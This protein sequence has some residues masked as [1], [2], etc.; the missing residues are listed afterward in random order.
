MMAISKIV[1]FGLETRAVELKNQHKSNYEIARILSKEAGMLIARDSVYEYFKTHYE[2]L[3]QLAKKDVKFHEEMLRQHL[4][5]DALLLFISQKAKAAVEKLEADPKSNPGRMAALL[6]VLLREVEFL[7]KRLGMVSDA[8]Q[9]NITVINQEFN[10]FKTIMFDVIQEVGGDEL[11]Q[12]VL[13]A[14]KSRIR[15]ESR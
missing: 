13:E 8:P 14:L 6:T 4:E 1:M 5:V 9:T 7:A 2:I 15:Q 12:K 10:E 3:K 11:E